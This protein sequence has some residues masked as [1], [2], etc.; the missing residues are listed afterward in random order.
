MFQLMPASS[1]KTL[2]KRKAEWGQQFDFPVRVW[3]KQ[4]A[5]LVANVTEVQNL[6]DGPIQRNP[7]SGIL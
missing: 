5:D 1:N 7:V 3:Q 4:A 6:E 2:I